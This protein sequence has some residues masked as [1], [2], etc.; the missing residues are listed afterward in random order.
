MEATGFFKLAEGLVTR[1]EVRHLYFM[2]LLIVIRSKS[3]HT[4]IN[5]E[6]AFENTKTY[7]N[8]TFRSCGERFSNYYL[9]H[10]LLVLSLCK[11]REEPQKRNRTSLNS[12]LR[13]GNTC[14]LCM[15]SSL[16]WRITIFR[17]SSYPAAECG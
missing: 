5:T 9:L 7:V 15:K 6:K 11:R 14:I 16:H 12:S 8:P 10:L 13:L 2:H 3:V 17:K 4:L 1:C